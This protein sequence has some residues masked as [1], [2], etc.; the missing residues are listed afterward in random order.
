[1][2]NELLIHVPD[3]FVSLSVN[4]RMELSSHKS[5]NIMAFQFVLEIHNTRE[6]MARYVLLPIFALGKMSSPSKNRSGNR[7]SKKIQAPFHTTVD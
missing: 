6:Q 1:M 7:I 3:F 2:C 4:G 5:G